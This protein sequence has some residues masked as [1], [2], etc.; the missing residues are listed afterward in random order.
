[1]KDFIKSNNTE[2]PS[3][4]LTIFKSLEDIKVI[5]DVGAREDL[6]Y[7]NLK[8]HCEYHLFEPNKEATEIL[9]KKISSKNIILNKFGLSDENKNECIYY[10]SSQSFQPNPYIKDTDIGIR[11]AVRKLDDYVEEHN[12]NYID[13]LK[14]DAEGFDYKIIKGGKETIKNKVS[15]V[16]FEYWDGVKKFVEILPNF[17]LFL[18]IEPRLLK[19]IRTKTKDKKYNQHLVALDFDVIDLIDNKLIPLGAGG[20][21][22]GIKNEIYINQMKKYKIDVVIPVYNGEKFILDAVKSVVNQT[23]SPTKIIVVDDGS[24]DNTNKIVSEYAKTYKVEIKIIKKENGGLSSAR[25]T[26]IKESTAD[27]I[28]FL[29]ADDIW[30]EN[31]LEKQITKYS[32]TGF[33]NLGLVYCKYD[34]IKENGGK[35]TDGYILPLDKKVQGYAFNKVLKANKILSSGSGVLIKKEV[36]EKVGMFDE[37]LKFGEDWDMWIRIAEKFEVDFVDDVLVHIRRH[38]SNMSHHLFNVFL[39]EIDFYNKWIPKLKGKYTIPFDWSDRIIF[40]LIM[41]K[42]FSSLKTLKEKMLPEV[43]KELFTKKFLSIYVYFIFFI[44][45]RTIKLIFSPKDFIKIFR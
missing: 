41:L 23:L 4:E 12:I 44:I 21:I 16:Q 10:L 27:F 43:Y 25:N 6:C 38:E 24:T 14:I 17:K 9:E 35:D 13:F 15:Y 30:I 22:F 2:I 5:F 11:Y 3:E 37:K 33:D 1:M 39:G 34:L 32:Y 26:G 7:F 8:P 18:M 36:F 19:A 40:R 20:N 31:K 42:R 45:R 28:A 29:D